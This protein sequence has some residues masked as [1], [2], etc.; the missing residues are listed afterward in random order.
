MLALPKQGV[1]TCIALDASQYRYFCLRDTV[2]SS[3]PHQRVG[4]ST[5]LE[6]FLTG[7]T[8]K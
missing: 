1:A 5:G 4:L 7:G 3:K 6:A 8:L 2:A